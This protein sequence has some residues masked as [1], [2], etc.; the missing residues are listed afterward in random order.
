[1]K[2]SKSIKN[3]LAAL[4]AA[5]LI[6]ACLWDAWQMY[7]VE[8]EA[9]QDEGIAE[10]HAMLDPHAYRKTERKEIKAII[11]KTE[12]AIRE[13]DD[14]KKITSLLNAARA[15]SGSFRT[16]KQYKVIEEKAAYLAERERK[17]QEEI[18]RK[19]REEEER[20]AAEAAAAAAAAAARARQSSGS[21]RRSSSS[22]NGCVGN[23][24][25]NFW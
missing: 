14:Q 13:T 23:S 19:R 20:R 8:V 17:R 9:M 10:L 2:S 7:L 3:P 22:S 4:V 18:E 6:A 1:M 15:Q 16:A 21:S 5:L 11:K 24:A 25:D 12:A